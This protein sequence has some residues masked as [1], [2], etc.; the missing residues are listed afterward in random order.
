MAVQ[1]RRVEP[2][3]EPGQFRGVDHADRDRLAVA[4]LVALDP[5]D[6]VAQRMP[7]VEDLPAPGF[8]QV[9]R[10]HLGLHP[11]RPLDQFACVP[12]VRDH[13]ARRVGLDQVEDRRVG[14]E[15]GLDHLGETAHVLGG[16]QRFERCQVGEHTGRRVEGADQVLAC[17]DVHRGLA[18]DRRVHHR[19]Q[20]RRDQD[21]P[22]AAQPGGRDE[23]GQVGGGSPADADDRVAAGEPVRRQPGPQIRR[24]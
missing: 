21:Q 2:P 23:P 8:P 13:G 19:E 10:D 11:H 1:G 6:R 18:A 3:G 12:A 9:R 14:D 20:G 5:L 22:D 7:V 15:P 17:F 24:H 16:R 4:D